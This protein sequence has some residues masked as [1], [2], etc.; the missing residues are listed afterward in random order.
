M[1]AYAKIA[2]AAAAV[3]IVAVVGYNLLPGGSTGVGGPAPTASPTADRRPRRPPSTPIAERRVPAGS[4]RQRRA[5]PGSCRRAA[6]T[7]RCL[8][9]PA[10][11]SRVPE[12]W[13]NGGDEAGFYGAVPGHARQCGRVRCLRRPRPGDLHGAASE[14]VLRLR[15]RARTIAGR[16]RPRWSPPSAANDS[17]LRRP[18]P[19]DVDDRRPDRQ[20]DSTSSS[21]PAGR[22]CCP[23]GPADGLDL[24]GRAHSASILLDTPRI[25]A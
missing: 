19:V 10:S 18:T 13:V 22:A 23:A 1:N 12:G 16:R 21:I 6:T 8:R 2:V 11:R 4:R 25:A 15:R 17:R 14:P 7:T 24:A 5:A 20:A 3:L 9:C